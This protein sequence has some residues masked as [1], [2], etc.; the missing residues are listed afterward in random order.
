[1]LNVLAKDKLD[2]KKRNAIDAITDLLFK[3]ETLA[4]EEKEE[5]MG[6]G[7]RRI[8]GS[9]VGDEILLHNLQEISKLEDPNLID[10]GRE[11]E[12]SGVLNFEISSKF[13][14]PPHRLTFDTGMVGLNKEE[15]K[16]RVSQFAKVDLSKLEFN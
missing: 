4:E 3:D 15:F 6:K 11:F 10:T 12:I 13:E 2:E 8:V 7:K 1:V 9:N 14:L 16:L 5:G